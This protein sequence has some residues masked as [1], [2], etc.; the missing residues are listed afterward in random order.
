MTPTLQRLPERRRVGLRRPEEFGT[1]PAPDY[2]V[3][4]L[5][6][7][8]D[9]RSRWGALSDSDAKRPLTEAGQGCGFSPL[10]GM[11]HLAGNRHHDLPGERW[12]ARARPADGRA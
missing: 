12:T 8:D 10:W 7:S 2:D 5:H 3:I 11:S 9:L 1:R 6:R 4:G